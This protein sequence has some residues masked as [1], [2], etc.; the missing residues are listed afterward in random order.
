MRLAVS[1]R[2][3]YTNISDAI[4]WTERKNGTN[5]SDLFVPSLYTQAVDAVPLCG[6]L[7][8]HPQSGANGVRRNVNAVAA[9]TQATDVV[10]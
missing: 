6:L 7:Q 2:R 5:K 4:T 9:R 8:I 10:H 1:R 3:A